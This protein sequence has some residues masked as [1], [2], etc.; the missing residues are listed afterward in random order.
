MKNSFDFGLD[1][2]TNAF[3]NRANKLFK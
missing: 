2:I 3:E 1:K